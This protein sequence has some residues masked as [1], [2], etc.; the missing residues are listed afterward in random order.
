MTSVVVPSVPKSGL[1]VSKV[2]EV[3]SEDAW[4]DDA[5]SERIYALSGIANR[6]DPPREL[7]EV[8]PGCFSS[9]LLQKAR[10]AP[11]TLSFLV[12]KV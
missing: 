10:K 6:I 12:S 1:Q 5:S 9:V 4:I 8:K 2:T 3:N 7:P 11:F